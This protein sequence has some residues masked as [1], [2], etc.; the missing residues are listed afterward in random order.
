MVI[1]LAAAWFGVLNLMP[2]WGSKTTLKNESAA[3]HTLYVP[4][5]V[6]RFGSIFETQKL[7]SGFDLCLQTWIPHPKDMPG[8]RSSGAARC[9][10]CKE[11]RKDD[12]FVSFE[13]QPLSWGARGF[14]PNQTKYTNVLLCSPRKPPCY[15]NKPFEP[16]ANMHDEMCCICA[17]RDIYGVSDV[18]NCD[19]RKWFDAAHV[20]VPKQH[21]LPQLR[22]W[23]RVS[24]SVCC[25]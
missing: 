6:P 12:L 23:E 19:T 3:R 9:T 8:H 20:F 5:C 17:D 15:E 2:P 11:H 18:N 21:M 7:V 25:I 22:M 1:W 16:D 4:I 24:V 10:T 14:W 13:P